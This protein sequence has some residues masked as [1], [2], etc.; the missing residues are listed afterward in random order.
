[1]VLTLPDRKPQPFRPKIAVVDEPRELRWQG[2]SFVSGLYDGEHRFVSGPLDGGTRTRLTHAETLRGVL[3]G[4]INRR[5]GEETAVG[6]EQMNEAPNA[7]LRGML[8]ATRPR[9]RMRKRASRGLARRSKGT[10]TGPVAPS[11]VLD[12]ERQERR[13]RPD[14]VGDPANDD[15]VGEIPRSLVADPRTTP[16]RV[17]VRDSPRRRAGGHV[18]KEILSAGLRNCG[19]C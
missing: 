10:E 15:R 5:I 13:Y 7:A 1:M 8:R 4:F 12:S 14:S 2:R 17:F 19:W 16:L 11:E 18:R 3:V 6:F 9:D